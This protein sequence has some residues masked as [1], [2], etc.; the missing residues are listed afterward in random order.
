MGRGRTNLTN[1]GGN[2]VEDPDPGF[3]DHDLHPG[4]LHHDPHS[5]FVSRN[6]SKDSLFTTAIPID[7]QDDNARLRFVFYRVLSYLHFCLPVCFFVFFVLL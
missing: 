3:V 2:P 4:L 7:S 1:S 5:G 6:F